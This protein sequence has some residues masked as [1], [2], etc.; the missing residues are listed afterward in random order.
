MYDASKKDFWDLIL[1]PARQIS[2]RSCQKR[3]ADSCSDLL[4]H[5][6]TSSLGRSSLLL[7]ACSIQTWGLSGR[8]DKP[9]ILKMNRVSLSFKTKD[10]KDFMGRIGLL[11]LHK[12]LYIQGLSM[13][14]SPQTHHKLGQYDSHSRNILY[15]PQ[16]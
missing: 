9:M 1:K 2:L 4:I 11:V 14:H 7:K 6:N 10:K 12:L 8:K 15:N 16:R 3:W 5:L 13:D